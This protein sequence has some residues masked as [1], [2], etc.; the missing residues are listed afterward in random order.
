MQTTVYNEK[1]LYVVVKD[2]YSKFNE[3]KSLNIDY[4]KPFKPKT[5][6]QL[7]FFFSA[8]CNSI[9]EFYELQGIDSYEIDDIKENLYYGCSLANERL[10]KKAKRFTGAEYTTPK[11]LS[12]MSVEEASMLIDTSIQL[13]DRAKCFEGLVLSPSIRYTWIRHLDAEQRKLL[14]EEKLPMRDDLY[15]AHV[16]QQACIW[17]GICNHSQ[18]HHL[19]IDNTG[20]TA[21]K[22]P[23]YMCVP[24]CDNC[25]FELHAKGANKFYESLK[26][27]TDYASI[28]DFCKAN[29]LRWRNKL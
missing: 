25:H 22:P 24:L 4:S 16:R 12:E 27:I 3:Y 21:I 14:N 26:W 19:R 1:M 13:I 10:L 15:M 6:A 5:K 11:R 2:M 7:G 28:Q 23:D 18:A 9:K 20:G 29:Y 8:L 17:C